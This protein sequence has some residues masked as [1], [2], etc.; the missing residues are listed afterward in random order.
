MYKDL[1]FICCDKKTYSI[2]QR[3]KEQTTSRNLFWRIN[4]NIFS[5]VDKEKKQ[6][7]NNA[8]FKKGIE[9][10]G[11][12]YYFCLNY[13]IIGFMY[14]YISGKIIEL[15]PTYLVI[16]AG[17]IGYNINISLTTYAALEGKSEAK[18]YV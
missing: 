2:N 4:K 3:E 7:I 15:N 11:N 12:F 5:K 13:D 9:R 1:Y 8:K 10:I 18:I 16:E 17:Q 14:E 6:I